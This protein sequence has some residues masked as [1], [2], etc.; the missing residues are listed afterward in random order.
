MAYGK[1]WR[2]E[3]NSEL[4]L[5]TFSSTK[6][7]SLTGVFGIDGS[8]AIAIWMKWRCKVRIFFERGM[9][10]QTLSN[11]PTRFSDFRW[12]DSVIPEILSQVSEDILGRPKFRFC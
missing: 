7:M 4:T 1:G 2:F 3:M 9:V 8:S 5:H 6:I 11:V 12:W 10:L